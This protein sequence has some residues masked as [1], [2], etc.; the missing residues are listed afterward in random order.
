[1]NM[2]TRL[3]SSDFENQFARTKLRN[4]KSIRIIQVLSWALTFIF[5]LSLIG[6]IYQSVANGNPIP[7]W[8][9]LGLVVLFAVALGLGVAVIVYKG[10]S[11]QAGLFDYHPSSHLTGELKQEAHQVETGGAS[12]LRADIHMALGVLQLSGG[13]MDVIEAA[14]TYD[15]A[16]WKPPVVAYDVDGLGQ[17]NLVVEQ[18][19]TGRAAMRQGPNEWIL[20]LNQNLPLDLNLRFG[21][22]KAE[23]KLVDMRLER[24]WVE[25]GVGELILDLSGEWKQGMSA[26]IKA[27]I[28]DTTLIL[29]QEVGVRIHS[30]VGLG[31]I[32]P[33]GLTWDG[34]AYSNA[35]YSQSGVD[36]DITIQGGVGKI[37]F[38]RAE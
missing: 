5:L 3:S 17:G 35:L 24:L 16:D 34:E 27:G 4:T 12:S 8:A 22:G 18:K 19:P 23:L 30:S 36:L 25:S 13:S 20:R 28:G 2:K 14:F 15:Q 38:E 6:A 32:R 31:S 1:M 10:V 33:Y 21:A 11:G 7:A 9:W 29:P 37:K 26:F